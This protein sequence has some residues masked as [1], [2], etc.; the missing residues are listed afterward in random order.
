[1]PNMLTIEIDLDRLQKY[2]VVKN[3]TGYRGELLA[4]TL[5]HFAR[6]DYGTG[7]GPDGE[8]AVWTRNG[9]YV[10]TA[11]V[12]RAEDESHAEATAQPGVTFTRE[13]VVYRVTAGELDLIRA[14]LGDAIAYR[15]GESGDCDEPWDLA[16]AK[17]YEPLLAALGGE[18]G[19]HVV[20]DPEDEDDVLDVLDPT[21]VV[22]CATCEDYVD[23]P[24]LRE[25]AEGDEDTHGE[26][27]VHTYTGS[28]RCPGQE[29]DDT[30]DHAEPRHT[31][32]GEAFPD[33]TPT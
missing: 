14:A 23:D 28:S 16:Y 24:R 1:M 13:Q 30:D 29:D 2:G 9:A 5:D 3:P 25:T 12:S 26:G 27:W 20:P 21:P 32:I 17:A 31:T 19:H 8:H 4:E 11:R 10:G 6:D 7:T 18:P 22:V 15:V 33:G